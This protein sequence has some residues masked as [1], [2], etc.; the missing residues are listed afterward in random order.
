MNPFLHKRRARFPGSSF[1]ARRSELL[2]VW[3]DSAMGIFLQPRQKFILQ[4]S[5]LPFW[6]EKALSA[7]GLQNVR[8]KNDEVM[9]K[10]SPSLRYGDAS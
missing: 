10:L 7:L 3:G 5:S 6:Q 8:F 2:P 4:N 9:R 1:C